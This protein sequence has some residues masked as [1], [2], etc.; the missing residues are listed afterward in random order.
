MPTWSM[1]LSF[2]FSPT[3]SEFETQICWIVE[4]SWPHFHC[5]SLEQYVCANNFTTQTLTLFC[6]SLNCVP[7]GL[8]GLTMAL[9]FDRVSLQYPPFTCVKSVFQ[10]MASIFWLQFLSESTIVISDKDA[11]NIIVVLHF[12]LEAEDELSKLDIKFSSGTI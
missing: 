4:K 12:W 7:V 10:S 11:K 3:Y 6:S 2:Y 1:S 8:C 5:L 9:E